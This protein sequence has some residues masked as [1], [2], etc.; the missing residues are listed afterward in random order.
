MAPAFALLI[1]LLAGCADWIAPVRGSFQ[2]CGT[3]ADCPGA[4]QCYQGVC[5]Q[6]KTCNRDGNLDEGEVCDDGNEVNDDACTN[7]CRMA[8]CG[9]GIVR[10]DL[11][12]GDDGYEDC[13]GWDAA[14]PD[15]CRPDCRRGQRPKRLAA[16]SKNTCL[17]D[18]GELYCWG[19][20]SQPVP[21]NYAVPVSSIWAT[22]NELH[23]TDSTGLA[24]TL[25]EGFDEAFRWRGLWHDYLTVPVH[26]MTIEQSDGC[27]PIDSNLPCY[28][29]CVTDDVGTVS[30]MAGDET[31]GRTLAAGAEEHL[32]SITEVGV[33]DVRDLA[34]SEYSTCAVKRSGRV[35]CWG[36]TQTW[37]RGLCTPAPEEPIEGVDRAVAIAAD[38]SSFAALRDDGVVMT[39]GAVWVTESTRSLRAPYTLEFSKPA[40]QLGSASNTLCAL[41]EDQTVECVGRWA[42]ASGSAQPRPIPGLRDVVELS[43]G[44]EPSDHLCALT[45]EDEVWCWGSNQWRQIRYQREPR[46]F[47]PPER[48]PWL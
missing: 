10:R 11:S 39:W 41:L 20:Y 1:A 38:K 45:D 16:M 25:R 12:P 3:S 8:R 48:V 46:F 6:T 22:G 13:E 34:M 4:L 18:R 33:T 19:Y 47:F 35:T 28:S 36:N 29:Q 26:A 31:C 5:L 7:S 42:S 43:H 37:D 30:C 21:I 15:Y 23:A 40:R 14:E 32:G 27:Q 9:D 24:Y 17:I 2:D 44:G